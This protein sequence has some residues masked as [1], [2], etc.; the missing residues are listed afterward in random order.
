R[1][2]ASI[3]ERLSSE[4]ITY[5]QDIGKRLAE[6]SWGEKRGSLETQID[7]HCLNKGKQRSVN[8]T[9][10]SDNLRIEYILVEW[11]D[12]G[13][14]A[15]QSNEGVR[16]SG[17][18]QKQLLKENETSSKSRSTHK[19]SRAQYIPL[20]EGM[21]DTCLHGIANFGFGVVQIYRHDE[22]KMFTL[23]ERW[24]NE[25]LTSKDRIVAV[26]AV[27]SYMTTYDFLG[28]V[29]DKVKK[30]VSHFRFIRTSAPNRYMVL[31]KFRRFKDA[32]IFYT[33]FNGKAFNETEPETCHVMFIKH[34]SFESKQ[35]PPSEFL[36]SAD[37]LLLP[38]SDISK[39]SQPVSLSTKLI[40]SSTL[41]LR[42]LPTC[43]VCL[44]RMDASVT[45]LLTILCQHTFH[46]QCLSKWGENNCPVCR[47]SQQ[48]DV[49]NASRADSQCLICK[50]QKNLWVCL[51]CGHIGCGRYDLAH[52]YDH[53]TSTGHSYS[54]DLETERVWD[55]AG[56][57]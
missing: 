51:I 18:E 5:Y 36:S 9:G 42:E 39:T 47:H 45:G 27:P 6:F 11:M 21:A 33:T 53:Y 54:M 17:D 10:E 12:M 20:C 30:Q 3:F 26:L 22:E 37:D 34:I 8:K 1:P 35:A 38:V 43:V 44:E 55:Y 46:C 16:E 7:L 50:I 32:K 15:G 13:E 14:M 56:D 52:A 25:K 4:D 28:F 24:R 19:I 48:K 41:G 31:L 40:P 49:L 29:G 2:K 23:D 57:G